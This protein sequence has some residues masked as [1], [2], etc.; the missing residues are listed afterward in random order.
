MSAEPIFDAFERC[1]TTGL[2]GLTNWSYW[3]Q[4]AIVQQSCYYLSAV[5]FRRVILSILLCFADDP[6][7]GGSVDPERSNWVTTP[8]VFSSIKG[9]TCKT[10]GT[11]QR[12]SL[13]E[14]RNKLD[15]Y[16]RL[17][18]TFCRWCFRM[19]HSRSTVGRESCSLNAAVDGL[20]ALSAHSSSRRLCD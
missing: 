10:V 14:S 20:M 17:F 11:A 19:A 9:L 8:C 13:C 1:K 6:Q 3:L 7:T 12:P 5:T 4:G 2:P 16:I 18:Y 15:K